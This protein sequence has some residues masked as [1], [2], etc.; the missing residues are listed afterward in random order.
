MYLSEIT[1]PVSSTFY[2]FAGIGITVVML[3]LFAGAI[4]EAYSTWNRVIAAFAVLSACAGA[5]AL[6]VVSWDA[7]SAEREAA[8]DSAFAEQL[9][10][11]Y[12]LTTGQSFT[13][14]RAAISQSG[15]ANVLVTEKDGH[16]EL[17]T[18]ILDGDRLI[19]VDADETMT[20]VAD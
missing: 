20:P 2:E 1:R 10:D 7:D 14:I 4:L 8:S 5:I 9:G 18:F 15:S 11:Q 19:L 17:T 13:D 12:G 3:I 16:S 6:S